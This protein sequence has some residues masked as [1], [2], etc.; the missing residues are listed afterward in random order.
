MREKKD[1]NFAL[2]WAK[3]QEHQDEGYQSSRK[4][5]MILGIGGGILAL[6]LLGGAPWL[7]S[8]KIKSDLNVVN[9]K[10]GALSEVDKQVRAIDA[11]N[12]QMQNQ[13]Q[14]SNLVQENTLDP[15]PLFEKLKKLLPAGTTIS[16][17]SL[18]PD[19]SVTMTLSVP[20]PVD[21]AR[22]WLSFENSGLFEKVDIK[23]VSLEDKTQNI[24]LDLK[25]K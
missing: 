10:I 1:F 14:M 15:G 2:R 21:V 3:V 25:L 22:F 18:Q 12:A 20:T 11:L 5:K 6:I 17:F 23:A 24:S 8:Y 13:K 19:K 7:W 4:R 9:Q 16:A